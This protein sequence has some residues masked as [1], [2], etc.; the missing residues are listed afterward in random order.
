MIALVRT[1]KIISISCRTPCN[2][3]RISNKYSFIQVLLKYHHTTHQYFR[4]YCFRFIVNVDLFW[5]LNISKMSNFLSRD[6]MWNTHIYVF[7]WIRWN[8][9]SNLCH[10][11]FGSVQCEYLKI[12]NMIIVPFESACFEDCLLYLILKWFFSKQDCCFMST[13][14]I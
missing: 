13:N 5:M 4:I 10:W 14:H 7:D 1:E 6:Q 12:F 11:E 2:F 3:L 9:I 8:T